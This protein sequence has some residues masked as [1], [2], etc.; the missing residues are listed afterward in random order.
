M[1][2]SEEKNLKEVVQRTF[3]GMLEPVLLGELS[4]LN[5]E[6]NKKLIRALETTQYPP[7]ITSRGYRFHPMVLEYYKKWGKLFL[8]RLEQYGSDHPI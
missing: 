8:E 5:Y 4:P 7:E 2:Q 1:D 6:T 3:Q